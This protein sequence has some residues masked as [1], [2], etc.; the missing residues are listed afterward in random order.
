[1]ADIGCAAV[2]IGISE[3]LRLNRMVGFRL[4][5]HLCT[6]RQLGPLRHVRTGVHTGEGGIPQHRQKEG[7]D[8]PWNPM[9]FGDR[10]RD[11][12]ACCQAFI[13]GTG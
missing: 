5:G 8:D 13:K 7:G 11:T 2:V 10:H 6:V 9:F 12:M 3:M 4:A 1:M